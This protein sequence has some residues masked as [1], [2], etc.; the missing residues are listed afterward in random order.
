MRG[1]KL[2]G[3]SR[4]SVMVGKSLLQYHYMMLMQKKAVQDYWDTVRLSWID[5]VYCATIALLILL[6]LLLPTIL[7]TYNLLGAD[8]A[9]QSGLGNAINTVLIG[10]DRLSFTNS[11]VTFMFWG[12][13]GMIVYG[14]VSSLLRTLQKAE[15]ERE[16][17]SDDY[18]HPAAFTR[19]KFLR[20]ELVTSATTF[21][22][23]L[24]FVIVTSVLVLQLLP[25][26]TL[27]LRSLMT[28]T[29]GSDIWSA[30]AATILLIATSCLALLTYKLWRQRK[31]LLGELQRD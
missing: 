15:L 11:V 22:T 20:E 5:I 9:L 29:G 3:E 13:V 25:T 21:V 1:C 24:L 27:H 12:V 26:T 7:D 19:T 17:V 23:F 4:A 28:S 30:F 6:V 18:V 14:F 2:G 8:E 16:L 10:I 31:V